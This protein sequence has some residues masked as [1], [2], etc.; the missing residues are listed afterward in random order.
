LEFKVIATI[1]EVGVFAS[2][3]GELSKLRQKDTILE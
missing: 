2:E 3:L 1:Q